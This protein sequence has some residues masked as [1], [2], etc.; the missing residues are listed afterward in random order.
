MLIWILINTP[1]DGFV[2]NPLS[3]LFKGKYEMRGD[4]NIGDCSL[5]VFSVD[6]RIDDGMWQCGVT[7]SNVTSQDALVSRSAKLTVQGRLPP[8]TFN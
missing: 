4:I 8:R 2:E 7:A 3:S 1:R 5:T 6:L